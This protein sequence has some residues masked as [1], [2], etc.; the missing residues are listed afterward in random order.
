MIKS[1]K[2][3]ALTLPLLAVLALLLVV[4]FYAQALIRQTAT[5]EA[6]SAPDPTLDRLNNLVSLYQNGRISVI[7]IS[8]STAFAWDRLYLF[9]PYTPPSVLDAALGSSWRKNCTTQIESSARYTLLLFTRD[10][11]VVH[12]LDY[13]RQTVFAVPWPQNNSGLSP[14]QALFVLDERGRLVLK[15]TH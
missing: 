15:D 4:A 9:E 8:A 2:K 1:S 13:P 5:P 7:E 10:G 6:P 11:F 14:R 3:S 12:C